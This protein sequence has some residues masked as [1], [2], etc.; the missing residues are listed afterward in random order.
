MKVL[1]KY[2]EFGTIVFLKEKNKY[3]SISFGGNGDLYWSFHSDSVDKDNTFIITKEN[4]GV[5]SLFE[6]L[7]SDIEN[8]NIFDDEKIPF[9]IETEEDRDEFL[10]I[11]EDR[12]NKEREK[13]RL[14]NCSNYNELFCD[15]VITWYSD[16]TAHEVSNFL[17]IYKEDEIFKLSFNIQDSI[18]GF[19]DDFHSSCYIP[20]R[21]RNSGS[22]YSPFN[23]VFMRMYHKLKEVDDVQDYGHQMHFEEYIY[24]KNKVKKLKLD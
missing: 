10:K 13:Y 20:I 2:K 12:M 1:K 11:R 22:S 3:I 5:Y 17:K 21:F 18:D 8:I 24:Q 14:Y 9:Y 23:V 7:F 19:D 6:Q 16:E 15:N 4:Y